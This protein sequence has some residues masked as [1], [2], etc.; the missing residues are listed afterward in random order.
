MVRQ[1]AS[2]CR[3]CFIWRKVYV[4]KTPPLESQSG[5]SCQR[6]SDE[7]WDI[8][9]KQLLPQP[10]C[11]ATSRLRHCLV[12]AAF[13]LSH[14]LPRLTCCAGLEELEGEE[15]QTILLCL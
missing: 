15:K 11:D 5:A 12:V 10:S 2:I 1:V 13:V 4:L 3:K 6:C 9:D 7:G 8:G 14:V